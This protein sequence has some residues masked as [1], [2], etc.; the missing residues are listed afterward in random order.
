MKLDIKFTQLLKAIAE[1]LIDHPE[2]M[3]IKILEGEKNIVIEVFC[4]GSDVGKLLGKGG[5][6][7][8]AIRQIAV[9]AGYR[10]RKSTKMYIIGNK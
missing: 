2:K 8:K 6:I 3:E 5:S 10:A 7:A 9:A 1:I 4:D